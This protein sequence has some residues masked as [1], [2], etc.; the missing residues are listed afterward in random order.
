M[1]LYWLTFYFAG[2]DAII[3]VISRTSAR[4]QFA[5][6]F[7][8]Q[9]YKRQH[10][11]AAFS[12]ETSGFQFSFSPPRRK[13]ASGTKTKC[14]TTYISEEPH[15]VTTT[16]M[17][18]PVMCA[19]RLQCSANHGNQPFRYWTRCFNTVSSQVCCRPRKKLIAM[20]R[21]TAEKT[22]PPE[23]NRWLKPISSFANLLK[24]FSG[25]MEN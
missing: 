9:T 7:S 1:V 25:V 8:F 22:V 21:W 5:R 4:Y 13:S 17:S 16:G 10:R 12:I 20:F 2:C 11:Y 6:T 15:K 19:A 18:Q 24:I 23:Q 3:D 14:G